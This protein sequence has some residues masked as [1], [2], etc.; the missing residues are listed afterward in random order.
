[1]TTI[2][3]VKVIPNATKNKIDGWKEGV[4]RIRIAA[5]PDKGKA[6][7]ALIAYLAEILEI[8]KSAI[9][10]LSGESSRIKR[11]LIE[12]EKVDI[13]LFQIDEKKPK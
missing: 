6:N 7:A 4:L 5:V 12:I 2:L 8:P 13:T 3:T 10:I 1:M 9:R 11:V